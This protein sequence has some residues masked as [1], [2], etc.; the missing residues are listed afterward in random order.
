MSQ[1]VVDTIG[2]ASIKALD[3][4]PTP[5]GPSDAPLQIDP[6]IITFATIRVNATGTRTISITNVTAKPVVISSFTSSHRSF[7]V[8]APELPATLVP[9]AKIEATVRF[10]PKA[11]CRCDGSLTITTSEPRK[12]VVSLAGRA[13]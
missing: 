13:N 3:K 11:S 1:P 2:A 5:A 10:S 12:V 4:I 7:V 8:D 6:P 9:G